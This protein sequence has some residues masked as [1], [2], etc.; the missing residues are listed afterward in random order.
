MPV[1]S[2]DMGEGAAVIEGRAGA[3]PAAQGDAAT[4][5]APAGSVAERTP[6]PGVPAPHAVH[7]AWQGGRRFRAGVEG[8]P[9]VV[10]DGERVEGPSP[11][12][13]LVA[14]LAACSAIDVVSILEKRRTPATDLSVRVRFSRAAT[15][16][17]RLTEAHL[18]WRVATESDRS[19]VERAI[20]LSMEKY[21]SVAAS[22]APDTKLSWTL[23]DDR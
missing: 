17:R 7:V 6:P 12:D 9:T 3:A 1:L 16:P 13:S 11:V 10:L 18:E 20:E 19:H 15:P 2:D 23:L 14:A 21:C 5:V 8:G 4:A 22:L